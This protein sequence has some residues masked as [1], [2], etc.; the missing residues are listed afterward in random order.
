MAF[1]PNAVFI[2]PSSLGDFEKCPQ[3]YY[4]KSVYRSQRG[5]KIQIINPSL[6]VGQCVHDTLEQFL[7]TSPSGRSK[8]ELFRI[9][10]WNWKSLSGE[11]GG[12]T[13][14][15]EEDGAKER[16]SSMLERFFGNKHFLETEA[17]KIPSFPKVDLGDD[18]I[19]T[20]KLDWIE[21]EDDYY[22]I[23]DFKTG[24]NEEKEDSQQLPI[25]ALLVAKILGTDKVKTSYWYLDKDDDI[26][27]FPSADINETFKT[28]KQKGE[29]LKL[30][31][32][33]NSYR[34]QSGNE[35]CWACK[36]M[37]E[38]AH[39]KGKLVH[40][41]PVNRKQE[42]YILVNEAITEKETKEDTISFADDLPF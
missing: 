18:L 37:H 14:K 1:N 7:K 23:I 35:Y 25:Y 24:K 19:L 30:V 22:H 16:A 6:A 33:T 3:L 27:P 12:F 38:V 15:E 32:Q 31:R 9:F 4:Y 41:D 34:C 28:L 8:D 36:D 11:K 39:G 42:I 26:K 17:V 10:E 2:S 5:L 13:L 29:I 40:V 21:K 20:G